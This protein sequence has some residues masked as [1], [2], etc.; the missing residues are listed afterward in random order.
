MVARLMASSAYSLT[1]RRARSSRL[2]R[3]AGQS[4]AAGNS[5]ARAR[6]A[7]RCSGGKARGASR[8]G[9]VLQARQ[10]VEEEAPPPGGDGVAVASELGGD[11]TVGG[12]VRGG[13][14]EDEP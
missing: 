2:Q 4:A 14:A 9:L 11:V 5:D 12:V 10:A 3:L 6:T 8:A 1:R 7:A 13:G